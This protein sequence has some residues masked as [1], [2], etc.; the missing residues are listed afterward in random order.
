MLRA[1]S[2][3]VESLSLLDPEYTFDSTPLPK[4]SLSNHEPGFQRTIALD[5]PL[6]PPRS[7][8]LGSFANVSDLE[9]RK[10]HRMVVYP[11]VSVI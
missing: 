2:V 9:P 6:K 5:C 8:S 10:C 11:I 3:R 1:L 7:A 4:D